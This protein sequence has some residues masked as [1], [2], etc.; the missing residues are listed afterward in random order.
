MSKEELNRQPDVAFVGLGN[1]FR[2]DDGIGYLLAR[3]LH[4]HHPN[5]AIYLIHDDFTPLLTVFETFPI[6]F[7][8]DAIDSEAPAGTI[9]EIDLL[10]GTLN[11]LNRLATSSHHLSLTKIIEL[12]R[13]MDILPQAVYLFGVVGKQ[14]ELGTSVS[15]EAKNAIPA[16]VRRC[17]ELLK[18]YEES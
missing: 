5:S 4:K 7:I 14:F 12:G 17:D 18:V 2:G 8:F 15:A 3:E 6:C 16:V 13:Q 11:E 1:P 9:V 10:H